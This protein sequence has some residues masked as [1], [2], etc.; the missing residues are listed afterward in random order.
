MDE[1]ERL[2]AP[3][4]LRF[5]ATAEMAA[6]RSTLAARRT[7][8]IDIYQILKSNYRTGADLDLNGYTV[9]FE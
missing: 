9:A 6:K 3:T 5:S 8:N 7:K 4:R 1:M 2:T